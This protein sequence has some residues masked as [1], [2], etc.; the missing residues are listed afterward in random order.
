MFGVLFSDSNVSVFLNG[1]KL[2]ETTDYTVDSAGTFI[3]MVTAPALNDKIDLIGFNAITSLAQS[4]Y[5]REVFTSSSGQTNFTL[6]TNIAAQD[7]VIPYV[8][9]IRLQGTGYVIHTSNNT[10]TFTEGLGLSE[11]VEFEVVTAGF[12]SGIHNAKSEKATHQSFANPATQTSDFVVASTE[13]A[14]LVGPV[15]INS[16]ITVNGN[17]TIV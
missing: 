3:T 7:D 2:E 14:M 11:I 15:T 9:G 12:R 8:N 1:V 5:V 6:S 13:N 16:D 17:L 4:S 10:I